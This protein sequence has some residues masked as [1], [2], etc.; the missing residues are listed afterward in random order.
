M[1]NTEITLEVV[2]KQDHKPLSGVLFSDF[3]VMKD[4]A[5]ANPTAG[6]DSVKAGTYVLTVVF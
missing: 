6:D 1:L 5:T 4:G 3:L 2:T